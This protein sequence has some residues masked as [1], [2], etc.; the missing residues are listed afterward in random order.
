M[1]Q[2]AG[3]LAGIK[4]LD[5]SRVLAGPWSSQ[6][7][8]DL[9][10]DVVKIEQPGRGDDTRAWGPPYFG[11]PTDRL[12]AYFLACNR[13]KKSVAIDIARPE[14]AGLVRRIA[15][16]SDVV[17]ENFKVGGLA[18]YGLDHITLREGNPRLVYCSITGFGMD[19]PYAARGGYDFLVQGM[20]GLMSVTGPVDSEAGA[21]PTKVGVP[22][23]DLFTGL[24]ATVSI[25][26]ALRHR[27]QTG[28]GQHIDCALLDTAVATLANQ[29][30]NYLVGGVIPRTMGNAHPNVVPYRDFSTSDGA[31][32]VAVGNDGQFRRLCEVL[33]RGDLAEDTRFA[34]NPARV[35]HR[36]AL[37]AE[38]QACLSRWRRDDLLEVMERSGIPGGPINRLDQVFSD[39]QIQARGMVERPENADGT[40]PALIRFPALLS[41]SPA[42]ISTRPPRLGEHTSEIL[43]DHL[44]LTADELQSLMEAGIVAGPANARSGK[45]P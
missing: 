27:D 40:D 35:A 28:E 20:G 38:L 5:L 10:A 26:A 17:I 44:S 39:P 2:V 8:G 3:P 43:G 14:G 32:I 24:Y 7:L 18:K 41:K 1:P 19:G 4:V 6:M 30:M 25:L 13:N 29:G 23:I 11:D 22:V 42:Q 15:A 12:S 36:G 31:V 34:T 9:G 37:E 21:G 16:E 45:A 33:G